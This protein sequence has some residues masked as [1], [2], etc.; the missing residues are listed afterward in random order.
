MDP[1]ANPVPAPPQPIQDVLPPHDNLGNP[2]NTPV[3][4]GESAPSHNPIAGTAMAQAASLHDSQTVDPGLDSV[5]NDVTSNIKA[6][7]PAPV[8]PKGSK[9]GI[10]SIFKSKP[11]IPKPPKQQPSNLPPH[12]PIHLPPTHPAQ[13]APVQQPAAAPPHPAKPGRQSG[14]TVAKKTSKITLPIVAAV[15]VALI[16]VGAAILAFKS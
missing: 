15:V 3:P 8:H 16:L 7:P 10:F 1:N 11:K 4:T 12:S 9:R 14:P 13:P 2:E 6:N 5:L